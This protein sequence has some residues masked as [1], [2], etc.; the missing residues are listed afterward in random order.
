MLILPPAC[1][2]ELFE[3][4]KAEVMA[5]MGATTS[6]LAQP[7]M[8]LGCDKP[9]VLALWTTTE[10]D[11]RHGSQRIALDLFWPGKSAPIIDSNLM[12]ALPAYC[13]SLVIGL[14]NVLC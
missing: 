1:R 11:L 8:L 13:L 10:E 4:V 7:G 9:S 5:A 6:S 14:A 3:S 12:L 2:M